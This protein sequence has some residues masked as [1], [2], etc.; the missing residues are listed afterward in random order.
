M[1]A[2]AFASATVSFGLVSI[3]VK[4]FSTAQ[5]DASV[6]FHMINRATGARVKQQLID[7]STGEVVE[8]SQ[9]GKGYEFSKGQYVVLSDE[10]YKALLAIGNNTIELV[11]FVPGDAV[12]PTYLDKSYYLGTDK[13]GERAYQLLRVAMLKAN[14]VGI[15]R[16]SARGKQHLVLLRPFER[17]LVMQQLHYQEALTPY[18]EIPIVDAPPPSDE[19][20]ALAIQIVEQR[21]EPSF[22]P[23]KFQDLVKQKMLAF[24]DEKIRGK[25]ITATPAASPMGQV[26][27]LMDALKKSVGMES[28]APLPTLKK[29]DKP[30]TKRGKTSRSS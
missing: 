27:D 15:A 19:E 13:G 2:R 21:R 25:E 14:L 20:L 11:E 23:A 29:T 28:D 6:K 4:M 10:E 7:A 16:Y 5:G 18:E 22:D 24:I 3:P 9:I 30:S 26:I 17:G 12:S 8:R 1:A